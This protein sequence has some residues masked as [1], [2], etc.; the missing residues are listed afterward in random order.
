[1]LV[2][3]ELD[4]EALAY[5]PLLDEHSGFDQSSREEHHERI[6]AVRKAPGPSTKML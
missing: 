3:D 2:V 4:E 1:M 6:A 5:W